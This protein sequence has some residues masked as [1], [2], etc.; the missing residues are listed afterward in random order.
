MIL[1]IKSA[2]MSR[3]DRTQALVSDGLGLN[4]GSTIS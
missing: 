3:V 4:S 2:V 1:M